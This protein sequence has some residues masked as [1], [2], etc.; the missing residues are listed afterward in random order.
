MGKQEGVMVLRKMIK[1]VVGIVLFVSIFEE[2]AED[3]T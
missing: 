2:R 1:D 3:A